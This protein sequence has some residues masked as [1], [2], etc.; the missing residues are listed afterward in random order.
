MPSGEAL[1]FIVSKHT[2]PPRRRVLWRVSI[3]DA[4]KICSDPRTAGA[5]YMLCFTT[6]NID[7]AAFVY[8]PDNGRHADVLHDHDIRV[9]RDHTTRQPARKR[10]V[11]RNPK[12]EASAGT[13]PP[14]GSEV[15]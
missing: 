5:H 9:I 12:T 11:H 6:E 15:P 3:A 2:T 10:Q 4:R 8:V 7:P 14:S 1:V 13:S